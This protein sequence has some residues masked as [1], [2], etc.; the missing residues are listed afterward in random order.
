MK[1][2][3]ANVASFLTVAAVAGITLCPAWISHPHSGNNYGPLLSVIDGSY[4]ITS[5]PA[6][7]G[8][9]TAMLASASLRGAD[10]RKI[11]AAFLMGCLGS[12]L[13]TVATPGLKLVP[14]AGIFFAAYLLILIV[15][16][17][18][19]FP[20]EEKNTLRCFNEPGECMTGA[21]FAYPDAK[22]CNLNDILKAYGEF[23]ESDSPSPTPEK[24]NDFETEC[25]AG[26][27]CN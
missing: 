5:I 22:E 7:V 4:T 13:S 1:N 27:E 20:P 10:D 16:S 25:F 24:E 21:H 6:V 19:F 3:S 11:Y 12:L 18:H 17:G 2:M 8:W 9:F 15:G 23:K 14:E 26:E